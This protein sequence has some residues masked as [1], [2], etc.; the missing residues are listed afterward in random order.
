VATNLHLLTVCVFSFKEERLNS[1]AEPSMLAELLLLAL[2]RHRQ[3]NEH[4]EEC[5]V[6][7]MERLQTTTESLIIGTPNDNLLSFLFRESNLS[8][9][10]FV[11]ATALHAFKLSVLSSIDAGSGSTTPVVEQRSESCHPALYKA[12]TGWSG[13][14]FSV[15]HSPGQQVY[16]TTRL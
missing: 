4:V 12:L 2:A 3:T 9:R 6:S 14:T 15:D 7:F 10:I 13:F 16:L 8:S 11:L 5:N 1:Y